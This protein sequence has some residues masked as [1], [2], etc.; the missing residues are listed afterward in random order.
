MKIMQ[1]LWRLAFG[2][3]APKP[4]APAPAKKAKPIPDTGKIKTWR[5][6]SHKTTAHTKS[7]A[8]AQFKAKLGLKRL[9]I[10]ANVVA[11]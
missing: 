11:V 8:R 3:P 9:P 7:E 6:D 4:A 5:W 1:T 10:G 2:L